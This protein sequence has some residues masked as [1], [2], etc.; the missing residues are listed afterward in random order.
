MEFD[1]N[2][3]DAE[4]FI[5]SAQ[6]PDSVKLADAAGLFIA[7]KLRE[8]SFARQVLTPKPVTARELRPSPQNHDQLVFIDEKE[9]NVGP[10]YA[11]NFKAWANGKY[12]SV[13]R[14]EIPIF[15]ISTDEW[16]KRE[17][18]LLAIQQPV[19]KILEENLV[20]QIEETEDGFFLAAADSAAGVSGNIVSYSTGAGGSLT[21]GAIKIG[22]NLIE[23]NQLICRTVL[24]SKLTYNDFYTMTYQDIGNLA[25]EVTVEGYKYYNVG[26]LKMIVSIKDSLFLHPSLVLASGDKA[27]MV[28]FFA[29]EKALGRFLVLDTTKFGVRRIYSLL[30]CMAWEAIGMA[31]ANAPAVSRVTLID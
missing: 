15:E 22:M 8:R 5:R 18:E 20:R 30:S 13:E 19:T 10:A 14:Y 6:G 11:I 12:I 25:E 26:G 9:I 24:M 2:R 27:H 21:K 7:R 3:T 16:S 17:I 28:Y 1:L 23:R 31:I 29:E 4:T